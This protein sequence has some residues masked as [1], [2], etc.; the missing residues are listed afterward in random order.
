MES[1]EALALVARDDNAADVAHDD[2]YSRMAVKIAAGTTQLIAEVALDE[3]R[4]HLQQWAR[5]EEFAGTTDE[6]LY[7]MMAALHPLFVTAAGDRRRALYAWI[8]L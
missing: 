3:L 7:A 6:D 5:V 1:E 8:R 4:P 2:D